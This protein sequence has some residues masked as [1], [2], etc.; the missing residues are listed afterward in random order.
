MGN[1]DFLFSL[2]PIFFVFCSD[3]ALY[4]IRPAS[5]HNSYLIYETFIPLM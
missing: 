3:I 2:T 4:V 1:F 5:L